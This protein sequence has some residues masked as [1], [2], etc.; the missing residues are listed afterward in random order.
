MLTMTQPCCCSRR[1]LSSVAPSGCRARSLACR[2]C[3]PP[4]PLL[5]PLP[6]PPLGGV[7]ALLPLPLLALLVL[8]P[9]PPLALLVLLPLLQLGGVLRQKWVGPS[10]SMASPRDGTAMSTARAAMPRSSSS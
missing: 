4:P 10:T 9:L 3:A 2:A 1:R 6:L 5:A 8:L 7:L